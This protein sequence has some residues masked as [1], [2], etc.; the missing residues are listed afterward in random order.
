M[1]FI[2]KSAF[3]P[4]VWNNRNDDLQNITAYFQDTSA[5]ADCSAGF[6]CNIA[7]GERADGTKCWLATKAA[8]GTGEIYICN[9]G[10]VQRGYIGNGLYA[11]GVETL[12][13]GVPAGIRGTWT[14]AKVGETYAFGEGNFNSVLDGSTNKFA[15]IVNGK[16]T[17]AA[18]APDAASGYYFELSPILGIDTFTESNYGAF[19][20]Y[21]M[22]C[23][24]I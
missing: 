22:V 14:K 15:T 6:L 11:E 13:L 2:E 5:D 3:Q 12:G 23:R 17:P 1:A 9:P 24:K 8:N 10:D 18:A 16:L 21:N 19:K 20:R 4:R 7:G